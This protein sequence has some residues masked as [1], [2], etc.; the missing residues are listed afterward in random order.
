MIERSVIV[1]RA[2][3][4][5]GSGP[6]RFSAPASESCCCGGWGSAAFAASFESPAELSSRSVAEQ[7]VATAAANATPSRAAAK[8]DLDVRMPSPQVLYSRADKAWMSRP[9]ARVA[10]GLVPL[11]NPDPIVTRYEHG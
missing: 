11:P 7:P 3:F 5:D 1:T 9:L 4:V 6:C 2:R 8:R 10:A